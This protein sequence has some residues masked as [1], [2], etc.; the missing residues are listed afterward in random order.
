M[1]WMASGN[2]P[3][4]HSVQIMWCENPKCNRPHVVLFDEH[5]EPF[6]EFVLPDPRPD[7]G[8]FLQDLKDAAY[9]SAVQRESP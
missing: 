9:S 4:A 3:Q 8:S 7:G 2:I 6:A 5:D 1:V